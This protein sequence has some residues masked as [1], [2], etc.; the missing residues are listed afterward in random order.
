[1]P[2][3]LQRAAKY[4]SPESLAA[5]SSHDESARSKI[6]SG[7]SETDS[8]YYSNPLTTLSD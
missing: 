1:V 6:D 7:L 5:I 8:E 3:R 4:E 2:R